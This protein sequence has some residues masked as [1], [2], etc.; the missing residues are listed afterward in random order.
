MTFLWISEDLEFRNEKDSL[1]WISADFILHK[2]GTVTD[3]D[4]ELT[5][6][7]KKIINIFLFYY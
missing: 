5:F 4:I 1:F 7:N 3:I 2:D 6:Q